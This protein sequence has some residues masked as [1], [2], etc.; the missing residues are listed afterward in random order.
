MGGG[1]TRAKSFHE[2]VFALSW[3]YYLHWCSA[4]AL[5]FEVS[6]LDVQYRLQ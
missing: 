1:L 5:A 6:Y 3:E 2:E 4:W